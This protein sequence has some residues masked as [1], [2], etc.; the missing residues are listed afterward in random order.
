MLANEL[1]GVC[2][3]HSLFGSDCAHDG[4]ES[5]PYMLANG[6]ALGRGAILE[7]IGNHWFQAG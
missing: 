7:D 4:H 2:Q 1:V 3:R 5:G 6:L